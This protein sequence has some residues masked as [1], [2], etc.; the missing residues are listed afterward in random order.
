MLMKK[1]MN[2]LLFYFIILKYYLAYFKILLINIQLSFKY[3][4]DLHEFPL[5]L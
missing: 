2:N 5:L 4:I 3:Q 1:L